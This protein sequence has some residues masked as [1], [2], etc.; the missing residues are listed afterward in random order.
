MRL[1]NLRA[2]I[3][4]QLEGQAQPTEI[5]EIEIP[6]ELAVAPTKPPFGH[7]PGMRG[8]ASGTRQGSD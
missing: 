5:G 4:I 7:T 2:K 6:I 1:T 8:S 3:L